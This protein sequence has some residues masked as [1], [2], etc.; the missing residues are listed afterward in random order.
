VN[1]GFCV[2]AIKTAVYALAVFIFLLLLLPCLLQCLQKLITRSVKGILIVPQ[3]GGDVGLSRAPR[4]VQLIRKDV[5]ELV[6]HK[7][8]EEGR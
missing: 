4:A 8:W 1:H 5:L 3:E 2:N 6:G 7:P